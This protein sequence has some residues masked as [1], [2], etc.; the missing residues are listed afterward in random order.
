MNQ[1]VISI[2]IIL[3]PGIIC[4]II[5]DKLT[6]H[7]KWLSFKFIVYSFI[8]G[9]LNYTFL[10]L[11]YYMIDFFNGINNYAI[12]FSSIDWTNLEIWGC[13][14]SEKPVFPVSE[15][16]YTS[17]L[18]I[19]MAF[20]ITTCINYKI[21]NVIAKK[22][23]VSHKYGDENLFSYYLNTKEIDWIYVRDPEID[24]TYQGRIVSYSENEHIQEMVLSEVTVYRYSDSVELYSLPT[25]YISKEIG[26]F[27]IEQIPK[28]NL[29]EINGKETVN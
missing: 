18:A 6:V 10:Q 3:I 19:P 21:F 17:I 28:E 22:I 29:G 11:I 27:I 5:C 13:I 2:A 7:S 8:L 25:I 16:I 14:V 20:F 9:V 23:N 24:L 12:N 15:I 26:R 4:V 1:L